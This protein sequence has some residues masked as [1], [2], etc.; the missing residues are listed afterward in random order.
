MKKLKK[1]ITLI[2]IICL[3]FQFIPAQKVEAKGILELLNDLFRGI[4]VPDEVRLTDEGDI[5][6]GN[7][8]VADCIT[9]DDQGKCTNPF[10]N[11]KIAE[12]Q[13]ELKDNQGRLNIVNPDILKICELGIPEPPVEGESLTEKEKRALRAACSDL[14][15]IQ[16]AA[17]RQAY[18]AKKIF[19][20]TDPFSECLFLRNC[21]TNCK[22]S[23]GE[24][25]YVISAL[26]ILLSITPVGIANIIKKIADLARKAKE[27]YT[28]YNRLKSLIR[29]G[30][31]ILKKLRET[32]VN[33]VTFFESLGRVLDIAM[34]GDFVK[35]FERY[36]E[37]LGK[38]SQAKSE[39]SGLIKEIYDKIM[40]VSRKLKS[41]EGIEFLFVNNEEGAEKRE[42]LERIAA[43]FS[44]NFESIEH[45]FFRLTANG[46]IIDEENYN[47]GF[48]DCPSESIKSQCKIMEDKST[49][50]QI[51]ARTISIPLS[52]TEH[53]ASLNTITEKV[54]LYLSAEEYEVSLLENQEC[55][56]EEMML[57]DNCRALE[58]DGKC[59]I[60][61][62]PVT[63]KKE[64]SRED[65]ETFGETKVQFPEVGAEIVIGCPAY[66]DITCYEPAN[67]DGG[68]SWFDYF[69]EVYE[70]ASTSNRWLNRNINLKGSDFSFYPH[71][72]SKMKR[73]SIIN[74][75]IDT[76]FHFSDNEWFTSEFV[77]STI[78]ILRD[79]KIEKI[80][81]GNEKIKE[82]KEN[83]ISLN[84]V[85]QYWE[86]NTESKFCYNMD[87]AV[88]Y[89][90][91][92]PFDKDLVEYDWERYLSILDKID[93]LG[94]QELISNFLPDFESSFELSNSLGIE[95]FKKFLNNFPLKSK[96][97]IAIG[98]IFGE[99]KDNVKEIR[100]YSKELNEIWF[101]KESEKESTK[102]LSYYI[103]KIKESKDISLTIQNLLE[104]SKNEYERLVEEEYESDD[105]PQK[106]K[107]VKEVLDEV[108]EIITEF[109][110]NIKE[111]ETNEM[112][113]KTIEELYYFTKLVEEME[114]TL[115]NK[116]T[117]LT[118]KVKE[119]KPT[120]E[121]PEGTSFDELTPF[122]VLEE[123]F[124]EAKK[125]FNEIEN[126]IKTVNISYEELS[127][128]TGEDIGV[129]ESDLIIIENELEE[130]KQ[131]IFGDE[132]IENGC[133]ILSIFT[134]SSAVNPLKLEEN[135][136]ETDFSPLKD[137]GL[138]DACILRD[139]I[140]SYL[141]EADL[142]LEVFLSQENVKQW[143][144]ERICLNEEVGACADSK[145]IAFEL[146]QERCL[147]FAEKTIG[148]GVKELMT[149]D[150][151]E[152]CN[153]LKELEDLWKDC[154]VFEISKA[155]LKDNCNQFSGDKKS[156]CELMREDF[157]NLADYSPNDALEI[158]D[159]ANLLTNQAKEDDDFQNE[160]LDRVEKIC[161]IQTES[162][163]GTLREIMDVYAVLLG[164]KSGT[165]AYEGIK[166]SYEDIKRAYNNVK[167]FI[168]SIKNLSEDLNEESSES[169]GVN[170]KLV[171]CIAK[172]ASGWE[173]QNSARGGPVCPEIDYLFSIVRANFN[174]IRQLLKHLD[175][176]RRKE[177]WVDLE[178]AGLRM[179]LFKKYPVKYLT[180]AGFPNPVQEVYKEADNIEARSRNLWAMATA[181]NF[182]ASNCTCGQSYC[183]L[184]L[185]ISGLPLALEPLSNPYCYL[186]YILR[187]PMK[188]QIK[189][190][191]N[192][193]K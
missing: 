143:W 178:I 111:W 39:A 179:S 151:K 149:E 56:E 4:N 82:E 141:T 17:A 191:E 148:E 61:C 91:N 113:G 53:S 47:E 135:C 54:T 24:I 168:D 59:I 41:I 80:R 95:I 102:V 131:I 185:C 93:Y 116:L 22:L 97:N 188:H 175:I 125:I 26:D 158:S 71:W 161:S 187:Y 89:S 83:L 164:I 27:I 106:I 30:I 98:N 77:T 60:E 16:Q 84:E 19:N 122:G 72:N 124:K 23:L 108:E 166:T 180:E 94:F 193:L 69:K 55:G 9:K 129:I 177:E 137:E 103:K 96:L 67:R 101:S 21:K 120:L 176:L 65:L 139:Q 157:E 44:Y 1:P 57:R 155:A 114:I 32:A 138:L 29:E 123:R 119:L 75:L 51:E 105:P 50:R 79:E 18:F 147:D 49:I 73:K 20:N 192:Y 160:K 173:G 8:K 163:K 81:E 118:N 99:L 144:K 136:R 107:D 162:I 104:E 12:D 150:Y 76:S 48:V 156:I 172:P 146:C 2:I 159:L 121:I 37:N 189:V 28:L 10:S 86:E 92:C 110:T 66:C 126:I 153:K 62:P 25:S 154:Q 165:A 45:L 170:V 68:E 128:K 31:N 169:S 78:A 112:N 70:N 190:L 7:W 117:E 88:S 40:Q 11:I 87:E 43:N 145:G 127:G 74:I 167:K 42:L 85:I 183:K 64:V 184:P 171:E 100:D 35:M 38:Y 115:L 109:L 6:I 134:G 182:A 133:S 3:L 142:K 58:E 33:L 36:S 90:E 15:R 14:Y 174:S 186:V 152:K 5:R 34:D 132:E 181:L 140:N 130:L 46:K 13:I 63:L 52:G